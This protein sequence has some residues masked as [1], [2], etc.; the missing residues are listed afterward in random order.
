[1]NLIEDI[2]KYFNLYEWAPYNHTVAFATSSFCD[3]LGLD[4]CSWFFQN[5]LSLHETNGFERG[6][7]YLTQIPRGSSLYNEIHYG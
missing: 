4:A 3:A 5:I 1:M 6:S 7:F 2:C